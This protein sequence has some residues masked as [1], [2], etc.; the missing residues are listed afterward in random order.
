MEAVQP[1]FTV[2]AATR[3]D[4]P[5]LAWALLQSSRYHHPRG[6]FE[7]LLGF[8]MSESALLSLLQDL[9]LFDHTKPFSAQNTTECGSM[10]GRVGE[11]EGSIRSLGWMVRRPDRRRHSRCR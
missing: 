7:I 10:Q 2:R 11:G 6:L 8:D 9:L 3:E 1:K 4:A 5:F